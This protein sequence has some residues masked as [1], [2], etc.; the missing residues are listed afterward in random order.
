[1]S[2]SNT[3]T[4][5][6]YYEQQRQFVEKFINGKHFI[7]QD[8]DGKIYNITI[9]VDDS[10][11]QILEMLSKSEVEFQPTAEIVNGSYIQGK[12]FGK[13]NMYVATKG[14]VS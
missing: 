1:M 4:H 13:Q 5:S 6:S 2:S 9:L 8:T 7:I 12:E 14:L 3:Q 10:T 11:S